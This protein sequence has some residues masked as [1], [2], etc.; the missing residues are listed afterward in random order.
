MDRDEL[1]LRACIGDPTARDE[2]GPL[3]QDELTSYFAHYFYREAIAELVQD[4]MVDVWAKAASE[5]PPTADAFMGW[6]LSYAGII[7]RRAKCERRREHTRARKR[8][9]MPAP[10]SARS[11][12]S[13]LRRVQEQQLLARCMR[14]LPTRY[15]NAVQNRFDGGTDQELAEREGIPVSTVR[16]RANRGLDK[17]EQLLRDARVTRMPDR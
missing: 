2:I 14:Q 4:T 15:R 5:A 3:L 12:S 9:R 16:S 6:V 11:P 17:L 13:A 10:P 1:V 7:V 8:Q